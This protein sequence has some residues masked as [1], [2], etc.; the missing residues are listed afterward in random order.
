MNISKNNFVTIQG[1]MAMPKEEGGLA[2]AGAE[3]IAYAL[4]YGFSQDD[5]SWYQGTQEYLADWCGCTTRNIRNILK[6]LL[7]KGYIEKREKRVRNITMYDYRTTD[8]SNFHPEEKFSGVQE[9]SSAHNYKNNY[10]TPSDI[11]SNEDISS[12]PKGKRQKQEGF[13]KPQIEDVVAYCIEHEFICDPYQFYDHFE[14]NGWLVSGRAKMK[15]WVAALRN[16]ERNE[17][18]RDPRFKT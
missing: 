11:S 6:S 15:D 10:T 16:W 8:V 4:L 5:K 14:A 12:P 18:K 1:W 3:L 13:V 17:R 9:K 2:L 7:D